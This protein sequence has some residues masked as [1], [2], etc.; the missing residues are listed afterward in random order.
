MLLR[1]CPGHGRLENVAGGT[2]INQV[3]WT[4]PANQVVYR[5]EA[6]WV[7]QDSFTFLADDGGTAPFAGKSNTATVRDLGPAGSHGGIPGVGRGG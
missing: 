6:G 2:P 3:P 1:R 7:G 5:P 4:L